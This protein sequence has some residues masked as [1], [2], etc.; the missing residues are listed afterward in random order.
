V[1]TSLLDQT[2]LD[3]RDMEELT[4]RAAAF[5]AEVQKGRSG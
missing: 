1:G 2:L 4:R 5:V 3:R